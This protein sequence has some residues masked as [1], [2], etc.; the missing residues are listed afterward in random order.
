MQKRSG[1][2]GGGGAERGLGAGGGFYRGLNTALAAGSRQIAATRI[3]AAS[4]GGQQAHVGA[5][6]EAAIA[7]RCPWQ[8]ARH[9]VLLF[10]G[11]AG[12]GGSMQ[13]HMS[14]GSAGCNG[15]LYYRGQHGTENT[16]NQAPAHTVLRGQMQT[17]LKCSHSKCS[18]R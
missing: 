11:E 6:E 17:K 16:G 13:L 9:M 4:E 1:R 18:W 5:R 14:V 15:R 8:Q 7:L 10:C 3:R 2:A 12:A